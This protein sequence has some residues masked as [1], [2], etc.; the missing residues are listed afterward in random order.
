MGDKV[1]AKM[2]GCLDEAAAPTTS[3][4]CRK[5]KKTQSRPKVMRSAS[6]DDLRMEG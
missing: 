3:M 1:E 2:D 5:S 6:L 4:T